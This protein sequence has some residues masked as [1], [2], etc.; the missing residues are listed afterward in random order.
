M[1]SAK[2]KMIAI[3]DRVAAVDLPMKDRDNAVCTAIEAIIDIGDGNTDDGAGQLVTAVLLLVGAD[4]ARALLTQ[5]E[6]FLRAEIV[7]G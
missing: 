1:I 5:A 2:D 7:L 4:K 6:D 3:M